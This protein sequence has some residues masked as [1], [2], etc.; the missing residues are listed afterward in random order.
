MSV[1]FGALCAPNGLRL[2][3]ARTTPE[4]QRRT[5]LDGHGAAGHTVRDSAKGDMHAA[6]FRHDR[7][8]LANSR[9]SCGRGQTTT[10]VQILG[11]GI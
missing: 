1:D 5:P 4:R 2:E 10:V 6:A 3:K 11:P 7:P 8:R 9:T